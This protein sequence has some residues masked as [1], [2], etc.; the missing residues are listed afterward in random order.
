MFHNTF[1]TTQSFA[2]TFALPGL[3][4]QIAW[5]K[6]F[7]DICIEKLKIQQRKHNET[8]PKDSGRVP[9]YT[10]INKQF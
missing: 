7:V 2:E 6:K 1:R 9:S 10:L 4:F 8:S 3:G 5:Y